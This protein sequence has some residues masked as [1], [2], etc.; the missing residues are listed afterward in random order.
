MTRIKLTFGLAGLALVFS[1]WSGCYFARERIDLQEDEDIPVL[2][3]DGDGVAD[4]VAGRGRAVP[5]RFVPPSIG[6]MVGFEQI[7]AGAR[8]RIERPR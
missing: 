7:T 3:E 6:G 5:P 1:A 8:M 4:V 2:D